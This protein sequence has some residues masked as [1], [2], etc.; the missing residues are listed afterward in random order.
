MNMRTRLT[1][2]GFTLLW[3]ALLGSCTSPSTTL[4]SPTPTC[5]PLPSLQDII[6]ND[7]QGNDF[8]AAITQLTAAITCQP[9]NPELL[10]LRGEMY[11]YLYEWDQALRDYNA[12]IQI[13]LSFADVYYLRGVLYYTRAEYA[14]AAADFEQYQMLAPDGSHST[15][16]VAYIEE[17][18]LLQAAL[19]Q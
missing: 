8:D 1:W 19:D 5:T 7:V 14:L 9:D 10:A 16:A 17:I 2:I 18:R 15:R 11:T 13:D 3:A 6:R 12:A 4:D